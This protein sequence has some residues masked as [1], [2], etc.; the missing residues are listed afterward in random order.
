MYSSRTRR[1]I[2]PDVAVLVE[3]LENSIAASKS[4]PALARVLPTLTIAWLIPESY[5]MS[6]ELDNSLS[7]VKLAGRTFVCSRL[8]RACASRL[9]CACA[10]DLAGF[11][12]PQCLLRSRLRDCET[13]D[14]G[15]LCG[16]AR[17]LVACRLRPLR[18]REIYA[19]SPEHDTGSNSRRV[20]LSARPR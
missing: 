20:A 6:T 14:Q 4:I 8:V 2:V 16:A 9:L 3:M 13:V 1:L 5:V 10:I 15:L 19:A 7:G 11:A 17:E 12:R 18:L